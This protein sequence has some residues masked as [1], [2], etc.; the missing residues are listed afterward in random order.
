MSKGKNDTEEIRQLAETFKSISDILN[1]AADIQDKLDN[2]K[3]EM[4]EEEANN[5]IDDLL[6]KFIIKLLRINK[7]VEKLGD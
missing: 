2:G 1:E 4:S 5:K 6:G 3:S 7:K